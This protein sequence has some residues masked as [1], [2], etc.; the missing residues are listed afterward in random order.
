MVQKRHSLHGTLDCRYDPLGRITSTSHPGASALREVFHY[1][2]A[3]NLVDQ[4]STGGYV[5][6][7]RVMTFEDKRFEYDAHGRLQTKLSG[8][9]THQHFHYDDEHRLI[10]VQTTRSGTTQRVRF[11][12]DALGRRIRKTDAFGTTHFLW[13]GLRMLQEQRGDATTTYVY[14]P[15]SYVP[16]ARLDRTRNVVAANEAS[17][18]APTAIRLVTV[19]KVFYFHN[20]A[21]GLP[22]ELSNSQGEL[23]WQAQ[24]RTW[25]N[26]VSESWAFTAQEQIANHGT[27]PLPQNLRFQGQ[28]LDRE[29][30]LHY[31]TFRFYDPDIGRFITSD[32]IGLD[33]GKNLYNYAPNPG[34]WIDPLGLSPSS[35][36]ANAMANAGNPVP[37]GYAAHHLIPTSVANN[38]Q[39]IQ[40]AVRRGI[41]NPNGVTN[42][43]ALPTTAAESLRSGKP[44]HSGGHLGS[45]YN[46]AEV[47]LLNAEAKLGNN[48]TA[49]TDR[50]ILQKIHA[51]E[52]S[53]R[54]SLG[55]D[56][57]RLQ[58]TDLRPRGTRSTC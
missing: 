20:D 10:E 2:A 14:E 26:T 18:D 27:I 41:Y 49:A 43:S 37:S 57:L 3:A 4:A 40:E 5:K 31:N 23:A 56:T 42:G 9:H 52:R 51:V 11:E 7:N 25:G 8:S 16:L 21:S 48:I 55:S 35:Q 19:D 28:Y 46:A 24:Y 17:H 44:L 12:Y 32:P 13:D 45:Y 6:H 58:S 38:S 50:Q 15:D 36:L 33:G 47:R 53:M 30:G 54:I 39:L 34:V 1:D 22:E 29:T